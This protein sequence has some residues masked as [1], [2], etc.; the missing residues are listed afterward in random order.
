[1]ERVEKYF[2]RCKI[3]Y[4]LDL[5]SRWHEH[6]LV[7]WVKPQCLRFASSGPKLFV[8]PCLL[9]PTA[10]DMGE[11]ILGL[12]C[13]L[14]PELPAVWEAGAASAIAGQPLVLGLGGAPGGC[15]PCW[16]TIG[17]EEPVCDWAAMGFSCSL[18]VLS[19]GGQFGCPWVFSGPEEPLA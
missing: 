6:C 1:M 7:A 13:V 15:T 8:P 12:P 11:Y 2:V 16:G 19:Q 10:R 3:G 14:G 5:C 17:V 4:S 9:L 18:S